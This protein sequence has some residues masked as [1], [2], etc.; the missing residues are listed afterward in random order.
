VLSESK[1]KFSELVTLYVESSSDPINYKSQVK[2]L[3]KPFLEDNPQEAYCSCNP[4]SKYNSEVP[5]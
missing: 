3:F 1:G 4:I 2:L 5:S